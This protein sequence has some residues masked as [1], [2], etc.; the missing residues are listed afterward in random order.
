MF[1]AI[2]ESDDELDDDRVYSLSGA[3]LYNLTND[4]YKTTFGYWK[5]MTTLG[6]KWTDEKLKQMQRVRKDIE[7]RAGDKSA[8]G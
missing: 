5:N 3:L 4:D 1:E 7:K 2:V 8:K 6:V